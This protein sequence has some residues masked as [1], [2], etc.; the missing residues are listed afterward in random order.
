MHGLETRKDGE[1]FFS[2]Q[3]VGFLKEL[4]KLESPS[5]PTPDKPESK[6]ARAVNRHRSPT[7]L[8][9]AYP[10]SAA[11]K[12]IGVSNARAIRKRVREADSLDKAFCFNVPLVGARSGSRLRLTS[13]AG[14]QG[15]RDSRESSAARAEL[16]HNEQKRLLF[17]LKD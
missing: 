10:P 13:P 14:L 7:A 15:Q 9:T 12:L 16:N 5:A 17:L 6:P 11:T 2:A 3:L 1:V 8:D 4:F